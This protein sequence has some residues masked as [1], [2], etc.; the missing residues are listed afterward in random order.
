MLASAVLDWLSGG[1]VMGRCDFI[2][3]IHNV[4]KDCVMVL[5]VGYTPILGVLKNEKN[6]HF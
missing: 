2:H 5:I 6:I 1:A 3:F 4:G